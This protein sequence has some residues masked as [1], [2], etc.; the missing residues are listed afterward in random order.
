MKFLQPFY[1]VDNKNSYHGYCSQYSVPMRIHLY[2]MNMM[3][4]CIHISVYCTYLCH[5]EVNAVHI[6]KYVGYIWRYCML[7]AC[8]HY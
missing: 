8:G 2:W 4:L 3:N 7:S 6:K 5:A 1:S